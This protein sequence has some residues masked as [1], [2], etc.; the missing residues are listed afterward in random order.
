MDVI[1]EWCNKS[2]DLAVIKL[3]AV[4]EQ[5]KLLLVNVFMSRTHSISFKFIVPGGVL[6]A[7][8]Q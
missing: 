1:C 2:C 5:V 7:G 6:T 8:H 4:K 3:I